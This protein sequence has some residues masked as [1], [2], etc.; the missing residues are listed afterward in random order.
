MTKTRI[1]ERLSNAATESKSTKDRT[2]EVD[3]LNKKYSDFTKQFKPLTA[4][5]KTH[6]SDLEKLEQSREK[7]LQEFSNFTQGT[8]LQKMENNAVI[9]QKALLKKDATYSN[10]YVKDIVDYVHEWELA[11]KTR[12]EATQKQVEESKQSFFHYEKKL[13]ALAKAHDATVAKGK[14]PHDNDVE[15]LKRNEEKLSL[16]KNSYESQATRLCDMIEAIVEEGWKD[17]LPLLVCMAKLE[18]NILSSKK[19]LLDSSCV[20]AN[21]Q[22]LAEEYKIDLT[23]PPPGPLEKTAATAAAAGSKVSPVPAKTVLKQ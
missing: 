15:K 5:L 1:G 14:T 18:S 4:A 9:V 19:Q 21:L 17:L 12:V 8:P 13:Q 11:V 6:V 22:N 2:S 23:T 20:I 7:V 16:S 10:L 3:E